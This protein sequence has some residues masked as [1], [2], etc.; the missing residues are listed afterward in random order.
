MNVKINSWQVITGHRRIYVLERQKFNIYW[1]IFLL[2]LLWTDSQSMAEEN[3]VLFKSNMTVNFTLFICKASRRIR[4]IFPFC[5]IK[6]I[7]RFSY[8]LFYMIFY[9]HLCSFAPSYSCTVYTLDSFLTHCFLLTIPESFLYSPLEFVAGHLHH[10]CYW[11]YLCYYCY[12]PHLH[13]HSHCYYCCS[14]LSYFPLLPLPQHLSH[15]CCH[16]CTGGFSLSSSP[17]EHCS[18]SHQDQLSC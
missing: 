6:N 17:P 5:G 9:Y 4:E 7:L 12:H 13:H 18:H 8:L 15:S 11:Y 1:L 16:Q 3:K 2:C 14:Y 10:D